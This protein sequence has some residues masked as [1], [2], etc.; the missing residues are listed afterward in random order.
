MNT[1]ASDPFRPN[2]GRSFRCIHI[3]HYQ[4]FELFL[5]SFTFDQFLNKKQRRFI[6]NCS[7]LPC[8][9]SEIAQLISSTEQLPSSSLK[10]EKFLG[11]SLQFP[12]HN[13]FLYCLS[14][15]DRF[16]NKILIVREDIGINDKTKVFYFNFHIQIIL[17]QEKEIGKVKYPP[18]PLTHVAVGFVISAVIKI[19]PCSES[20][21]RSV[22][23]KSSN[24]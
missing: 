8:S 2:N 15:F 18:H 4:T 7:E 16:S 1:A 21:I 5:F 10:K 19:L 22:G 20:L 17:I 12:A 24:T 23:S 6:K 14:N 3:A 11:L 13:K 9:T